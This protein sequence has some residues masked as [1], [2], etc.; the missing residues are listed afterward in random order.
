MQARRFLLRT[1]GRSVVP[2]SRRGL[3][4]ARP[5]LRTPAIVG[6]SAITS[7]LVGFGL[8]QSLANTTPAAP[9]TALDTTLNQYGNTKD[10]SNVLVELGQVLDPKQISVDS[11]VLMDYGGSNYHHHPAKPHRVVV[12]PKS[13]EQV[14]YIVNT[15]RKYRIPMVPY[16][17]GTSLEG[18]TSGV[19]APLHTSPY[20][21][22]CLTLVS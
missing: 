4:T 13:T 7:G 16:A 14:V 9:E 2:I 10:F 6:L 8:A 5:T 21:P 11:D 3:S 22:S 17:G 1:L 15:C 19:R 20:H 12:S 18:H